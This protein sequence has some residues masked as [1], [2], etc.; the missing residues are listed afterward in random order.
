MHDLDSEGLLSQ[1]RPIWLFESDVFGDTADP[2]KA[3]VRRQGMDCYI[4]RQRLLARGIGPLGGGRMPPAGARVIFSGTYACLR[5]IVTRHSWVPGGWCNADTL[6][7]SAYYPQFAPYLLNRRHAI[8]TGI[9]AIRR[10]DELFADLGRDGRLFVRPDC[11]WKLFTGRVVSQQDFAQAL[12][13]SRY[14]STTLVMIAQPRPIVREWRLVVADG[15]VIASSQ[16]F[17]S[18]T[19]EVSPGC[20][21]EVSAFADSILR[22]NLWRPDQLFMLDICESQREL[23]L[24]ELNGFSSSAFYGCDPRAVVRRASELAVRSCSRDES[25]LP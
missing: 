1:Q 15:E 8:L 3:E 20:P 5:H 2:I 23:Y 19:I 22:T 10:Q 17:R 25:S 18:G 6:K 14:D 11:C 7:C 4:V 24:L 21:H 12:A 16:Y 9:E 13:P